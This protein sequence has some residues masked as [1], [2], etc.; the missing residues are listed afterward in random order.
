MRRRTRRPA[1]RRTLRRS[2]DRAGWGAGRPTAP[3]ASGRRS[4]RRSDR[5]RGSPPHRQR[6]A[7]SRLTPRLLT[8]PRR[9]L[10]GP[11]RSYHSLGWT[12]A[13][14]ASRQPAS[15]IAKRQRFVLK[16]A[17]LL[18]RCPGRVPAIFRV[19]YYSLTRLDSDSESALLTLLAPRLARERSGIPMLGCWIVG[20][21][22]SEAPLAP[23]P[24]RTC[25]AISRGEGRAE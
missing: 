10:K 23:L 7:R 17:A 15:H 18:S 14:K 1:G 25:R 3:R 13:R 5:R 16:P 24:A 9:H 21:V 8:S 2:A 19:A 20:W 6:S 4:R 11:G 22:S 12:G